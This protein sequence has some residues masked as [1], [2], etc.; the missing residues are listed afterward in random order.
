M[1]KLFAALTMLLLAAGNAFSQANCPTFYA[2]YMPDAGMN[3]LLKHVVEGLAFGNHPEAMGF[4]EA[5]VKTMQLRVIMDGCPDCDIIVDG[6]FYPNGLIKTLEG[7][8]YH[9]DKQWRLQNI[10]GKDGEVVCKYFYNSKGRLMR[11]V[12]DETD[13]WVYVYDES[14]TVKSTSCNALHMTCD[15]KN[16]HVAKIQEKQEWTTY[17]FTFN[18][19][20]QGRFKGYNVI[21]VE[22]DDYATYRDVTWNY[23]Q[24]N[25]PTSIVERVWDYNTDTNKK[26]GQPETWT[27]RCAYTKDAKD[28][29]TS[30][31]GTCAANSS[32]NWNMKRTMTYYTDEEVKAALAE[33]D[34]AKNP[35]KKEEKQEDMWEF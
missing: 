19:D 34:A 32:L 7:N 1:K 18:Y 27:L 4:K 3:W 31:K 23:A 9:Y 8:T 29:W 33:K 21:L 17:P 15:I 6:E 2:N 11:T 22:G 24:G 16:G 25:L 5:G 20:P 28:N 10:V 30:W 14:G 26:T 12:I 13:E 35:A